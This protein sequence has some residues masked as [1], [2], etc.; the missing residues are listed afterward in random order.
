MRAKRSMASS[1]YDSVGSSHAF[2]LRLFSADS[3]SNP[4]TTWRMKSAASPR[5]SRGASFRV[6]GSG[7]VGGPLD[8]AEGAEVMAIRLCKALPIFL[9]GELFGVGVS[10]GDITLGVA[11]P[12]E[13]KPASDRLLPLRWTVGVPLSLLR[14]SPPADPS[15]C[16]AFSCT[17]ARVVG[18]AFSNARVFRASHPSRRLSN[19]SDK[20]HRI[21][22]MTALS[23]A[24]L[25]TFRKIPS[26]SLWCAHCGLSKSGPTVSRNTANVSNLSSLTTGSSS[27]SWFAID[28]AIFGANIPW[29]M[30]WPTN[31]MF[32]SMR[33]LYLTCSSK[34]SS[35]ARPSKPCGGSKY[36]SKDV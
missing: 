21:L 1:K 7:V 6:G 5:K 3:T 19:T 4:L 8:G 22:Q 11:S 9:F 23:F 17:S 35:P 29:Q 24:R 16:L 10:F 28:K 30:S 25:C 26:S 15:S 12:P 13:E 27:A 34:S 18:A 32:P 36:C 2:S 33:V 31:R 20:R 14:F